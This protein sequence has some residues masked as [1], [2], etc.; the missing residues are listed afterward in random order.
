MYFSLPLLAIVFAVSIDGFTVGIAYGIQ[1]QNFSFKTI[2]I[3]MFC[4]GTIVFSSMKLGKVIYKIVS[5][6]FATYLGGI[7]LIILGIYLLI[8]ISIKNDVNK[9]RYSSLDNES[10]ITIHKK[11]KTKSITLYESFI[12]GIALSLDAFGAGLAISLLNFSP[13]VSSI[14]ISIM[15]GLFLYLGSLIGMLLVHYKYIYKCTYISPIILI[16]IGFISF[17]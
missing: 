3:I 8:T 10:N 5:P 2:L 15:S 17:F 11:M 14:S 9:V 1:R 6:S 7:I 4:S 12:L 13:F 16:A